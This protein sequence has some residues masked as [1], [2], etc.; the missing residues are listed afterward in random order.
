MVHDL[1]ALLHSTERESRAKDTHYEKCKDELAAM[2]ELF[3][4]CEER[5]REAERN[6][7]LKN[8]LL[9]ASELHKQDWGER[10]FNVSLVFIMIFSSLFPIVFHR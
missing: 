5:L 4:D 9:I 3:V 2:E 8:R 1:E 6:V 7:A 10:L